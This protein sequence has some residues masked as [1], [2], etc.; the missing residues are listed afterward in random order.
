MGIIAPSG[1]IMTDD[2]DL[3]VRDPDATHIVQIPSCIRPRLRKG[4]LIMGRVER[5]RRDIRA[6]P[7]IGAQRRDIVRVVLMLIE[8]G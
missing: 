1:L 3:V 2:L 5:R 8:T 4:V 7:M 6:V